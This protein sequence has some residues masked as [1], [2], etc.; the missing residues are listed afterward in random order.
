MLDKPSLIYFLK[1]G[2]SSFHFWTP[3][4]PFG[5][6]KNYYDGWILS[7]NFKL[8]SICIDENYKRGT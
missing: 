5:F 2:K 6:H 7:M 1:H 3:Y 8:F 4:A